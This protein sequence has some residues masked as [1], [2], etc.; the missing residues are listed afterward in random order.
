M[1]RK[2]VLSESFAAYIKQK[3]KKG[4]LAWIV[5]SV[6]L[7]LYISPYLVRT[8]TFY[9]MGAYGS[10]CI[11]PLWI[12]IVL[13]NRR[14][15]FFGWLVLFCFFSVKVYFDVDFI[16]PPP[17]PI[18][19]SIIFGHI[20]TL[21]FALAAGQFQVISRRLQEANAQIRRLALIDG[22]TELPNHR[23]VNEQL[24]RE[25]AQV[26]RFGHPLSLIFLDADHFKKINDTYGHGIGDE[27][28]I[29]LGK[30][31]KS[32]LKPEDMLGRYGGEEFV[33]I[34][35]Q[36]GPEDALF[37]AEQIRKVVNSQ[38]MSIPGFENGLEISVSVGVASCPE[39]TTIMEALLQK[40]DRAMYWS[41]RLGR[42]QVCTIHEAEHLE[43][44]AKQ[45]PI[46]VDITYDWCE[47]SEHVHT[48]RDLRELVYRLMR[49]AD[50]KGYA[51]EVASEVQTFL[52]EPMQLM[53]E[54]DQSRE[55]DTQRSDSSPLTTTRGQGRG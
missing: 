37:T 45:L 36:L 28:L 10:F 38:V 29:E 39:D 24:E 50:Q 12:G 21:I 22:L 47:H 35:P 55:K 41:K 16:W 8:N 31:I 3:L 49:L 1:L 30:R 32:V 17:E 2:S 34:L 14:G 6:I 26:Q 52:D 25:L 40:A 7:F 43:S 4:P 27:V 5:I 13:R 15:G 51:Q 53:I 42:N 18:F 11:V 54:N 48:G 19:A 46:D 20:G 23:A 44:L 33:V 9:G